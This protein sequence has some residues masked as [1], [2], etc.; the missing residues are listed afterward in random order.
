MQ[1]APEGT[2]QDELRL[3]AW[4]ALIGSLGLHLVIYSVLTPFWPGPM[5]DV[6]P[7]EWMTMVEGGAGAGDVI[8]EE[9]AGAVGDA[10]DE[11]ASAAETPPQQVPEQIALQN[12]EPVAPAETTEPIIDTV[13]DTSEEVV[14]EEPIEEVETQPASDD[15][16]DI[17]DVPT[18]EQTAN[19]LFLDALMARGN[20]GEGRA[21]SGD[22]AGGGEG[23]GD[24]SDPIVGTWRARRYDRL[25]GRHA[26]FTIRITHREGERLE[27]TI[28]N[29]A[30]SGGPLQTS[31]PRCSPG[32]FDHTVTMPARGRFTGREF[33]MD[34]QSHRRTEHC[35]DS[36]LWLYNLDHF[37]GRLDD[38]ELR[39]VNN[40]GGIEVNSPY[41]FR[42]V[43][44]L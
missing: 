5:R 1:T 41:R 32:V 19:N 11:L 35:I 26:I 33:R 22:G 4:A 17:R 3:V 36:G 42:R 34:A 24:C 29:R 25:H 10:Y 18:P 43:S 20:V 39:T 23:G 14:V 7:S 2:H 44:C 37:T 27:G 21:G 9:E 40:D 15:V 16:R 6:E 38:G 13:D 31:P 12:R 30:W 8:D 28:I